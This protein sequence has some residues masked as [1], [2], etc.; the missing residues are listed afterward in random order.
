MSRRN[1]RYERRKAK[2]EVRRVQRSIEVGGLAE[3]FT[4]HNLYSAGKQCCNGVRWKNSTQRFE[5]HLFSGTAK[6]RR[7]LLEQKWKPA[8]YV[9][10]LLSERGKTRPIDAPRIQ[11]RQIHKTFTRKVLLPLYRPSMIWNNGASLPGTTWMI[12]TSSFRPTE[13]RKRF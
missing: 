13:I 7:L 2:R 1:G 9:H 11:D 3:V 12:T 10:F 4:Y 8:G 5:Q 6:R